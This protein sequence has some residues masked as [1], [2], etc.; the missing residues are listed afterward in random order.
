MSVYSGSISSLRTQTK[1]QHKHGNVSS[2][3]M[4]G[5]I[6]KEAFLKSTIQ[7]KFF[8]ICLLLVVLMAVS[9]STAYFFLS[10][11]ETH[12]ESQQRIQVAFDMLIRDVVK[13]ITLFTNGIEEFLD[14]SRAIRGAA[15]MYATQMSLQQQSMETVMKSIARSYL[16]EVTEELKRFAHII[17]VDRLVLYGADA[18]ILALYQKKEGKESIGLSTI[19][20]AGNQTYL[21]LDNLAQATQMLSGN[22]P[23]PDQLFPF[24]VPIHYYGIFPQLTT[25]S[26]INEDRQLGIR[27]ITPVYHLNEIVGILLGDVFYT[28]EWIQQ[29]AALSQ[30]DINL[31]VGSQ[32]SIGSFPEQEE[33][34]P[35]DE[36]ELQPHTIEHLLQEDLAHEMLDVFSV[37]FQ[38]EEYY[39]ANYTLID[40]HGMTNT[41]MISISKDWEKRKI[42]RVLTAVLTIS[43]VMM[44][45]AFGLT[46]VL[47]RR[48]LLAIHHLV[49]VIRAAASGNL[50]YTAPVMSHDEFGLLAVKLNEMIVHLRDVSTQ[51]QAVAHTVTSTAERILDE[52]DTLFSLME[53]QSS[54]VDNTTDAIERIDQFIQVVVGNLQELLT[55][56]EHILLSIQKMSVNTEEVAAS[57]AHLNENLQGISSFID[58][59]SEASTQILAH[60]NHLLANVQKTE[61]EIQHI[62]KLL[63]NVSRNAEQSKSLAEETVNVALEGQAAA[64]SSIEGMTEL[65]QVVTQ[66]SQIM[67]EVNTRSNQVSAILDIVDD[68]AEKTN[69]LSLNASII[70]AQAGIHGRGFAV[71][72]NE[73]R[74]LSTQTKHSTKE[75]SALIRS[76]HHQTAEGVKS[77]T[78]GLQKADD[79]V[80]LAYDV[81]DALEKII[82][83]AARSSEFAS[84]TADVIQQTVNSNDVIQS[85]MNAVA[86]MTSHIQAE[87]QEEEQK[88]AQ[89]VTSIENIRSMSEQVQ[90]ANIEQ[91]KTAADIEERMDTFVKKLSNISEQTE[92]LQRSSDQ[93]VEAMRKID[94]ITEH[95]LRNTTAMSDHTIKTL[96]HQS[97]ALQ[98]GLSVF[99]VE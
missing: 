47:S 55:I 54:S 59:V 20:N 56:T 42:R 18:S 16:L 89:V 91:T 53:Q 9:I 58:Q 48:S 72:A 68:I 43:G 36:K 82:E 81:Q 11:Q 28:Q 49:N 66:F 32:F 76:L 45:C 30:T 86:E 2:R 12:L 78:A 39:Q 8:L 57:T 10:K 87:I 65:K 69:L 29:Y 85:S 94:M 23:I 73:I 13:Q 99:H 50:R 15:Y 62:G 96:V 97:G 75:I 1:Q 95:I 40:E 5:Q 79:S 38:E 93:I 19:S 7:K 22:A 61:T 27:I 74:D 35:P 98:E 44:V 80:Q 4:R 63:L 77:V 24:G 33:F 31:Y 92:Q 88:L 14:D 6:K 67:H 51:T 3:E 71:V 52:V 17:N 83:C 60:A 21:S 37:D 25:V 84:N 46:I 64:N 90:Q 34:L 41:F 70:S 26:L